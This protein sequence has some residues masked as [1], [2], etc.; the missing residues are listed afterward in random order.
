MLSPPLMVV[1]R[2]ITINSCIIHVFTAEASTSRKSRD[3]PDLK[4]APSSVYDA[5]DPDLDS[6]SI[7][8][9]GENQIS[10]PL[11]N[12]LAAYLCPLGRARNTSEA[13]CF[14]LFPNFATPP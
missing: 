3:K 7:C 9:Y 11:Q 10:S 5:K 4:I 12:L 8:H 14:A 13:G 1:M 6:S 2:I